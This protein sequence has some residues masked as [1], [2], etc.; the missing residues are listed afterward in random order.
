MLIETATKPLGTVDCRALTQRVL[1][2]DENIWFANPQRQQLFDV[3]AQ[4]QSIVLIFCEGWPNVRILKHAGWSHL[5]REATPVMKE[6]IDRFYPTGGAILRAMMARLPAG[7]SI[8]RHRD[9]H[10][11]FSIAHRIHVPLVTNPD[12]EF[13]VD[14]ERVPTQENVAVEINNRLHHQVANRGATDRIHF[15]FDYA[16]P[17]D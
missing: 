16:P 4:T 15:I 11:S 9:K 1:D 14:E 2:L 10:P 7:C 12:V 5:G 3:H 13:L 6:V 17:R 8:D